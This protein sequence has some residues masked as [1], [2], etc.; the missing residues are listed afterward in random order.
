M[1]SFPD[2]KPI[3]VFDGV[4]VLCSATARWLLRHDRN[5]SFRFTP[6]QSPL[7]QAIYTHYQLLMDKTFL[8]IEG[9]EVYEKS[10]ACFCIVNALGG[11]W[12]LLNILYLLPKF[13]RDTLYDVVARNRYKW[14]GTTGYCEMISDFDGKLLS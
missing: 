8:V 10:A 14:F 13:I 7:G 12:K 2:D 11:I 1:P 5:N 6:A 9:G 3:F 4:C